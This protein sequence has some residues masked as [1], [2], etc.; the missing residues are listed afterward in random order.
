[1]RVDH[2]GAVVARQQ[3]AGGRAA[4]RAGDGG[5]GRDLPLALGVQV[6]A[7]LGAADR[8][9]VSEASVVGVLH[10]QRGGAIG[11][12]D[13]AV[14]GV[15]GR[16]GAVFVCARLQ[17]G[18]EG[19]QRTALGIEQGRGALVLI[20]LRA[21]LLHLPQL[22]VDAFRGMVAR[23]HDPL[24][25]PVDD[26]HAIRP[27]RRDGLA[28][29]EVADGLVAGR[30]QL[31]PGDEVV[32]APACVLGRRF[33]EADHAGRDNFRLEI[34][35]QRVGFAVA[36][37]HAVHAAGVG[38]RIAVAERPDMLLDGQVHRL[39]G[40]IEQPHAVGRFR[41]IAQL[42]RLEVALR[43]GHVVVVAVGAVQRDHRRPGG[44]RRDAAVGQHQ[45]RARLAAAMAIALGQQA[46]RAAGDV[47]RQLLQRHFLRGRDGLGLEQHAAFAIQHV[48]Q[49]GLLEEPQLALLHFHPADLVQPRGRRVAMEP[50][51]RGGQQADG[52]ALR[53]REQHVAF[54]V[55]GDGQVRAQRQGF[56]AARRQRHE[57]AAGRVEEDI[58]VALGSVGLVRFQFGHGRARGIQDD[59]AAAAQFRAPEGLAQGRQV[60]IVLVLADR[61]AFRVQQHR[62]ARAVGGGQHAFVARDGD[63][64]VD[65]F[66]HPVPLL[67]HQPIPALVRHRDVQAL[68][69]G[70]GQLDAGIAVAAL[71]GIGAVLQLV[72]HRGE[73]GYAVLQIEGR[74]AL[75]QR[76]AHAIALAVDQFLAAVQRGHGQADFRKVLH[77]VELRP[78]GHPA[79]AIDEA[80]QALPFNGGQAVAEIAYRFEDR[81]DRQPAI[82]VQEAPGVAAQ[83]AVARHPAGAFQGGRQQHR[84][85]LV[86]QRADAAVDIGAAQARVQRGIVVVGSIFQAGGVPAV[87][88]LGGQGH[89]QRA[90]GAGKAGDA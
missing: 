27:E 76:F 71:A 10:V 32:Q 35:G 89:A 2:A 36:V 59:V 48:E 23:R 77:R 22:R 34:I 75:V 53:V 11:R 82:L 47:Q 64:L 66:Q 58:A 33:Q 44:I 65:G 26:P 52:H 17:S 86:G 74:H 21:G 4:E 25:L 37:D 90:Q 68:S 84:R 41:G 31:L 60:L 72:V 3:R 63:V 61:L 42:L 67:V 30:Q 16:D 56:A 54:I 7:A 18:Q 51:A 49:P 73:G 38:Q 83:R 50:G 20:L 12:D 46:E 57:L 62:A 85:A 81:R 70:P 45:A 8:H 79:A 19:G 40:G 13:P 43:R 29:L 39:A 14:R 6:A 28:I 78:H 9:P 69:E 87:L 88:R 24:A 55:S 15:A 80:P 5:A 1:M